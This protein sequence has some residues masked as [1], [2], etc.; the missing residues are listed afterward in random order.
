[1]ACT[2]STFQ[3]RSALRDVARALELPIDQLLTV[4]QAPPGSTRALIADLCR[5]LDDLPR[6][7]GQHNGG[8]VLTRAPLAERVP[9]EPAAMPG[10]VVVQWDKDALEEIGLV[11][12]DLLGL[13][14]LSAIAE[15]ER[16][17]AETTG[18]TIDLE[19]L[20]FDDE[21]I[22]DMISQVIWRIIASA[23]ITIWCLCE[24]PCPYGGA[25]LSRKK[26]APAPP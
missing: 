15:A 2:F 26:T 21:R 12:I 5:Q 16:L 14:M 22:F 4:D 6:H 24:R 18:V 19:R 3:T 11:K 20:T 10:R 7:L 17:I 13:R 9:T 23:Q 25:F 8:M 1:M